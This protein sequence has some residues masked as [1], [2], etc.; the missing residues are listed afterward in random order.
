MKIYIINYDLRK[1][2]DYDTLY[3]TIRSYQ[4]YVHVLDSMWMIVSEDGALSIRDHLAKTMDI[5]DGLIVAQVTGEAAW[6][7]LSDDAFHWLKQNLAIYSAEKRGAPPG[8]FYRNECL[9]V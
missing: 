8:S 1:Q 2:R 9:I 5:D 7:K 4:N 3:K 6:M